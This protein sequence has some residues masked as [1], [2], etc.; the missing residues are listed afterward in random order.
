MNV[1]EALYQRHSV[2]DFSDRP[3]EQELLDEILAAAF[4]APSVSNTQPY[5]VAVASGEVK[6]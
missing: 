6:E 4:Q 5:Q 1:M 2:R 3:V